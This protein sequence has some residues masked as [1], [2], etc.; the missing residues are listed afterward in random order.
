MRN[1][2]RVKTISKIL[3]AILAILI[4]GQVAIA[5]EVEIRKTG[6]D[7][8]IYSNMPVEKGQSNILVEYHAFLWENG[9]MKDLKTLGGKSSDAH[10]I[11]KNGYIVGA[12]D[13]S[14]GAERAV[15]WKKG[16]IKNIGTL[17]TTDN[18][19]TGLE[20]NDKNQAIGNC[21]N[22]SFYL[23]GFIW[24]EKNGIRSI[25]ELGKDGSE[26]VDLNNRGQVIG[27]SVINAMDHA[28]IWDKKN[29]LKD[30]GALSPTDNSWAN[31]INDKGQVVGKSYN[32]QGQTLFERA[33]IWDKVNGMRALSGIPAG[34]S[35]AAEYINEK[36]QVVGSIK[37]PNGDVGV[38]IWD[39]VNGMKDIGNLGGHASRV[40]DTNNKGQIVGESDKANGDIHAFLWDKDHGMKDLGALGEKWS[41]AYDIN[42]KSQIIGQVSNLGNSIEHGF[43]IKK[44]GSPMIN[45]GSLGGGSVWPHSINDKGQ[46]VGHS[47]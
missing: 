32:A 10:D 2:N 11:N 25:G 19:C 9:H 40:Y 8:P 13:T 4:L 42:E 43:F 15:I 26:A 46:I 39:K 21:E 1:K 41:S 16:K 34:T 30:L 38:F 6:T 17:S 20:I 23:H 29:G 31:D 37:Y 36:G 7:T 27:R 22:S 33:F 47:H 12:S 18:Y 28:I 5:N 35:T 3:V 14:T 45:I 44:S 24:D